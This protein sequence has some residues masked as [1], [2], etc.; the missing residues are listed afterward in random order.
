[1]TA[2]VILAG[3]D[4]LPRAARDEIPAKALVI[5]ADSGLDHARALGLDLDLKVGDFDSAT[6]EAMRHYAAVPEERWPRDKDATDLE[7]ALEVAIRH[8]AESITVLGGHG[9][10]LDHLLGNAALLASPAYRGLPVVWVAGTA[11]VTV[12]RGRTRLRG[13]PRETVSL[14]P[15]GGD[16]T[17]VSTEGLRW[18]LRGETLPLGTSRGVSNVLTGETATVDLTGGT[19]LAVQPEALAGGPA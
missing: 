19:L 8:R 9:G 6:P 14:I 7:I 3:G 2:V 11:R 5:A 16:A 15:A 13:R 18:E 4:P 1:M 12:V 17:G 10:R